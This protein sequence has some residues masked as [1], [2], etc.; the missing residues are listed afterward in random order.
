MN[1]FRSRLRLL[2]VA[3][4]VCGSLATQAS[5]TVA[6]KGVMRAKLAHSQALLDGVVTSNWAGLERHALA[7]RRVTQDPTWQVLATLEY[8]QQTTQFN[9][10]LDE[11]LDAVKRKDLDATPAAY[12]A[13]TM[14]CVQC[15]RYVA[16]ARMAEAPP[17]SG[18]R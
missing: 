3:V 9:R 16:R 11:L 12:N 8:G 17:A 5:Q 18:L 1:V 10:T 14:S 13:L 7:L 6:V 2:A 4:I 15:H